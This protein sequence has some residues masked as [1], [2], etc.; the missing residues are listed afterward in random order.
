[1]K[2]PA[3]LLETFKEK[4]NEQLNAHYDN[5]VKS[6]S[7]SKS[8]KAHF[9]KQYKN[10]DITVC[11]NLLNTSQKIIYIEYEKNWWGN[12]YFTLVKDNEVLKWIKIPTYGAI[13]TYVRWDQNSFF[14]K[15]STH[16]GTKTQNTCV[17]KKNSIKCKTLKT[18][19]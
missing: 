8:K 4:F 18:Y 11:P 1:M 17:I 7:L 6:K 19:R 12:L 13:T 10:P 14:Y 16:M 9:L 5:L 2:T 3:P 15:N